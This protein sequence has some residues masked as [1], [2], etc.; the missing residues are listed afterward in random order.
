MCKSYN[1]YCKTL[2]QYLTYVYCDRSSSKFE[3][4]WNFS[5]LTENIS[6]TDHPL[7]FCTIIKNMNS[8]DAPHMLNNSRRSMCLNL[9]QINNIYTYLVPCTRIKFV[10]NYIHVEEFFYKW[11][12]INSRVSDICLGCCYCYLHLQRVWRI[13]KVCEALKFPTGGGTIAL[14]D[15]SVRLEYI[16]HVHV[17][18]MCDML[19]DKHVYKHWYYTL[20]EWMRLFLIYSA[21]NRIPHNK[22]TCR[23]KNLYKNE[24][25]TRVLHSHSLTP[26]IIMCSS[27]WNSNRKGGN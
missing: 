2:W 10:H 22:I 25:P 26:F 20:L 1:V 24:T 9:S 15:L 21:K 8:I 27:N 13:S 6:S 19:R 23:H 7:E 12:L 11:D 18:V 17:I 16:C 5:L 4:T 3:V 14:A